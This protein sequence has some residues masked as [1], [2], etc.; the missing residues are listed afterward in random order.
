[1]NAKVEIVYGE[2]R[3]VELQKFKKEAEEKRGLEALATVLDQVYSE[4]NLQSA[5]TLAM[6]ECR[7]AD[8]FYNRGSRTITIC[9]EFY[10]KID[11]RAQKEFGLN[12][13]M[14]KTAVGGTAFFFLFHEFGH[15]LIH[16]LNMPIT[17]HQ[18]DVADQFAAFIFLESKKRK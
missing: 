6:A 9:Y 12:T 2:A 16:E 4:L 8:T 1:V 3:S 14:Y 18:E 10:R 17:G 15:A 11:K 7:K 13:P 5:L